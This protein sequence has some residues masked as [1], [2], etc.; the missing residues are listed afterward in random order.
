[1]RHPISDV[2]A[3]LEAH[4]VQ[5]L[6]GELIDDLEG[7]ELVLLPQL[8]EVQVERP[9]D[10]HLGEPPDDRSVYWDRQPEE[11]EDVVDDVQAG[12]RGHAHEV[13]NVQQGL[14]VEVLELGVLLEQ[15]P[16]LEQVGGQL[17]LAPEDVLQLLDVSEIVFVDV[18]VLLKH[19]QI[20]G[21][22]VE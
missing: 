13:G 10:Y 4:E 20:L 5:L 14:D 11:L 6:L 7:H 1:M 2:D 12:H 17:V 8:V 3:S 9:C 16:E 21:E 19:V 22:D 15:E 18:R